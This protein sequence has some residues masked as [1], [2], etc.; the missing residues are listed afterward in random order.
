MTNNEIN[1]GTPKVIYDEDMMWFDYQALF[2]TT[3]SRILNEKNNNKVQCTDFDSNELAR[4][5]MLLGGKCDTSL[6]DNVLSGDV[7]SQ[8][9]IMQNCANYLFGEY[10]IRN[11]INI[12]EE[13][14]HIIALNYRYLVGILIL[15]AGD[16]F[17]DIKREYI[18]LAGGTK[19]D[20]LNN[21][22][23]KNMNLY[24]AIYLIDINCFE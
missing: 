16:K 18:H 6:I 22:N 7:E 1:D 2:D 4:N 20:F 24:D 13:Q 12:D 19:P 10:R 17:N 11:G 5:V 21:S 15:L 23:I 14:E 8:Y 3:R 9:K